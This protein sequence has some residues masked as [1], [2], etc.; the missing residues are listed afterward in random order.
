MNT[1]TFRQ[2]SIKYSKAVEQLNRQTYTRCNRPA[3]NPNSFLLIFSFLYFISILNLNYF[4]FSYLP[5]QEE[6]VMY[7]DAA[8]NLCISAK[9]IY[10]PRWGG[11]WSAIHLAIHLA[12][13]SS[14]SPTTALPFNVL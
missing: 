6:I 11:I 2:K 7:C 9:S 10:L 4:Y 5:L 1:S 13:H 8:G 3:S 14:G 12:I